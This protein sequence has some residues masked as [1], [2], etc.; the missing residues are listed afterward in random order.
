M[1]DVQESISEPGGASRSRKLSASLVSTGIERKPVKETLRAGDVVQINPANHLGAFQGSFAG[2][3]M[4]V[5]EVKAWGAQG[6]FLIPGGP[7]GEIPDIAYYRASWDEL[8][9]VG[10]AHWFAEVR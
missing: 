7:R 10:S 6:H 9:F 2:C 3:L 1:S 8:A 5:D 4:I